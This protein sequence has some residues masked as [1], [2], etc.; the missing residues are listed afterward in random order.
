MA[1]PP[2]AAQLSTVKA[3]FVS[4]IDQ[5]GLPAAKERG[6][7]EKWGLDVTV[8][9]PFATG[10]DA[11]NAIQAGEVEIVQV[12]VPMIGA[13]LRG[14]ELQILGSY[15]G[16][17]VKR[18]ADLTMALVSKAGTGVDTID[19]VKG[20]RVAVSNGTI[21]HLYMLGLLNKANLRPADVTLV[22]TPPPEMP[23]A[24]QGGGVD[25]FSCWDPWPIIAEQTVPG[26]KV[27]QRG[28]E[29]IDYI[30]YLV[31][32][33][34][35][36]DRSGDAVERLLGARAEA[37]QW[38]RQNP[39][40]TANIITRWFPGTSLQVA[41]EAM[42]YEQQL[43]DIR[44]SQISYRALHEA[45]ETLRSLNVITSTFDVNTVFR[46]QHML[47]VMETS[48]GLFADLPEIP[49]ELQIRPGYV[50]TP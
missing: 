40:E 45:Q 44:L 23:V 41:Q 20:K 18:G 27:V 35:Y 42:K 43:L 28:G 49:A 34:E 11:L 22:N 7:F 32:L 4:G 29:V 6:F 50:F 38:I 26:A 47:K 31:G 13:K 9:N 25:A 10:V 39:T 36:V 46:P 1:V 16:S 17:A 33:R 8:A 30:G 12:G 15:N 21:N 48:P 37:D 2:K 19:D 5:V 24:L 3:G 14:M